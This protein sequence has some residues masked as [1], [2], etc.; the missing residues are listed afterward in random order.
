MLTLPA[1][2]LEADLLFSLTTHSLFS[3]G[4]SRPTDASLHGPSFVL[5]RYTD[6]R[7]SDASALHLHALILER[8]GSHE[9][10]VAQLARCVAVLETAYEESEDPLVER[11]FAIAQSNLGRLQLAVGDSEAALE[12][13]AG[14]L[15]LAGADDTST[16][17]TALRVHAHFGSG[18]AYYWKGDLD[19]TLGSFQSALDEL[20]AR[21]I[22]HAK[23]KIT[24]LLAQA[25]WDTGG[26]EE[27]EAAK[28][29]LLDTF[30][31]LPCCY[32]RR[33]DSRLTHAALLQRDRRLEQRS[34]R[35]RACR[36]GLHLA[37]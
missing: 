15:G 34:G 23:D 11:K 5:Q 4:S 19:E 22:G 2:Q 33:T 35:H 12:A 13:F 7:P 1:I 21:P 10:A 9:P 25:L 8:L 32:L 28:S 37:R 24:V 20:D 31:R 16:E 27:M 36:D 6:Q 17:A 3:T 30:V 18:L 29:T 26:G 14:A